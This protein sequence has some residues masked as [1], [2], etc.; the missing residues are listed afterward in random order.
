MTEIKETER[1]Y[2]DIDEELLNQTEMNKYNFSKINKNNP[3]V[4]K[5]NIKLYAK[6]LFFMF[7]SAVLFN[8]GV[9]AFLSAANT[10]PS[11]VSGIP[12]LITYMAPVT[13]PYFALMY[14]A[15]NIPLFLIFGFKIKRSFT[16]LTLSF[17]LFQILTNIIFTLPEVSGFITKYINVAPGWEKWIKVTNETTNEIMEFQNPTT[18]PIFIN[19]LIGSTLLGLSIAI[20][21]KNGGST[22]GTDIIAFYFST[23]KKKSIA[24]ILTIISFITT[25][26][27]LIIF[28]TYNLTKNHHFIKQEYLNLIAEN[29]KNTLIVN[30][31]SMSADRVPLIGMSEITT[32]IY[33]F[34]VNTI[35]AIIYPKYKKVSV[36]IASSN[37][38]LII[39][40]LKH[41]NYWHAYSI[42]NN[43]S[44]YTG[45]DVYRIETTMLLFETRAIIRDLKRLDPNIWI[46]I[47]PVSK[48]IGKFSTQFVDS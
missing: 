28:G 47:K 9:L 11:G 48:I 34:V 18:W 40:Y 6:R 33:I 3:E 10:I 41:I 21:W 45:N 43:K 31:I 22:G 42:A 1:N 17:M 4:K 39:K 2:C 14:L 25:L 37:P 30:N 32:I 7:I 16:F 23:Q 46:Q 20:A 44:G 12:T 15:C 13:K 38:N 27:F 8:F 35:V 29:G 24:T 36:S 5:Q 19:G 26:T